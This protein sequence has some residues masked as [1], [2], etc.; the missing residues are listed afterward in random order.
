MWVITT[1]GFVAWLEISKIKGS[2]Y[3]VKHRSEKIKNDCFGATD[4]YL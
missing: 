3:I 4:S 2:N 1:G